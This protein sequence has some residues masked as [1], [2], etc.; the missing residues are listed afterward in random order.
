MTTHFRECFT[1]I[2]QLASDNL[3]NQGTRQEEHRLIPFIDN[4]P[5]R[6]FLHVMF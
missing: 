2:S 5:D 1:Q 6:T 3:P 4:F